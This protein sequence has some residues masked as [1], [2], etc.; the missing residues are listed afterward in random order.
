MAD[1]KLNSNQVCSLWNITT[2]TT[3]QIS[4]KRYERLMESNGALLESGLR[5][6]SD[7]AK[8]NYRVDLYQGT[9]REIYHINTGQRVDFMTDEL[10]DEIKRRNPSSPNVKDDNGQMYEFWKAHLATK[11]EIAKAIQAKANTAPPQGIDKDAIKAQI[12]AEI[13]EEMKGSSKKTK[14]VEIEDE[15]TESEQDPYIEPLPDDYIEPEPEP[16]AKP[17]KKVRKTKTK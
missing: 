6:Y 5:Q 17:V 1:L 4:L 12:L 8:F 9:P 7:W 16:E 15:E 3:S 10:L 11:A 14:K 2:N 13:R